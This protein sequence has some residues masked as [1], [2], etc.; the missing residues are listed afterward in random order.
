MV[1]DFYFTE[2]SLVKKN[3]NINWIFFWMLPIIHLTL[4]IDFVLM[5]TEHNVQSSK[6]VIT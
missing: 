3:L 6:M 2:N 5:S 1:F 4:S